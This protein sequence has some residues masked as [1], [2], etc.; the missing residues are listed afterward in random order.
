MNVVGVPELR[1]NLSRY[2]RRV[3]AGERFVVNDHQEPMALPA[4]LPE[5]DEPWEQLLAEWQFSR[6]RLDLLAEVA[7]L[8]LQDPYA[9]TTALLERREDNP[10]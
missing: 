6:P 1:Q 9:G 2:L 4:P 7:P 10:F 8:A 3:A 5:T